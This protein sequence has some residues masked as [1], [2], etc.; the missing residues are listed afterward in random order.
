MSGRKP[1]NEG[2]NPS[3]L[4]GLSTIDPDEQAQ[5][6][7]RIPANDQRGEAN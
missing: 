7:R 6:R 3:D 4:E 1:S 2:Y 5:P